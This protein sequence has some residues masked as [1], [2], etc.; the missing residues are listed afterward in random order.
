MG[1]GSQFA[2]VVEWSDFD[3]EMLFWK[4]PNSEIK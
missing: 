1:L 3:E 4:C 2:N